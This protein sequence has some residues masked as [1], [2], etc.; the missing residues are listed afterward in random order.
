MGEATFEDRDV[1]ALTEYRYAVRAVNAAGESDDGAPVTAALET[2]PD[3]PHDLKATAGDRRVELHWTAAK[4]AAGYHVQR[5]AEAGGS[6][7]LVATLGPATSY[8]DVT[9]S[10]GAAIVYRLVPFN[11]SG[12]GAPSNIARAVP[13]GPPPAPAGLEVSTG[14]GRVLLTWTAAKGATG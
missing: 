12:E 10:N 13:I 7:S 2:I 6:F 3:A 14:D 5:A 11:D 4:G 1:A 8:A 9:V